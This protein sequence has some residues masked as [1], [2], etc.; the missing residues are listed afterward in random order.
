MAPSSSASQ[1]NPLRTGYLVLYNAISTVA[2]FNVLLLTV[3]TCMTAGYP[4][5]Y[6]D[7]GEWTRWTQT[8]A[9]LEIVHAA[10][11][12]LFPLPPTLSAI[13]FATGRFVRNHD[14]G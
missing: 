1:S 6:F 2:W 5:V 9:I 4:Y 12:K 10:L 13:S 7:A 14:H 11:G 8:A 3:K